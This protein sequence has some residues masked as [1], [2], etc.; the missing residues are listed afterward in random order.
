MNIWFDLAGFNLASRESF[1]P[2]FHEASRVF[3]KNFQ[4][5]CFDVMFAFV[6]EVL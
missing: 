2:N 5:D 3:V 6:V 1:I 4:A